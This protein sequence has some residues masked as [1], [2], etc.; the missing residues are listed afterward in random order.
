ML[1]ARPNTHL[2]VRAQ[3]V[4]AGYFHKFLVFIDQMATFGLVT[5]KRPEDEPVKNN[6]RPDGSISNGPCF[7]RP[8]Q[9]SG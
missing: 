1:S 5:M 7:D 4:S 8:Q 6:M 2:V 9:T 3:L